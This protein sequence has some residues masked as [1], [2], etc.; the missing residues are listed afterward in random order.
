MVSSHIQTGS[1]PAAVPP[2]GSSL[3][4]TICTREGSANTS[5]LSL[6]SLQQTR[7]QAREEAVP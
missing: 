5:G 2:E 6:K 3:C 7:L 4:Q 1:H